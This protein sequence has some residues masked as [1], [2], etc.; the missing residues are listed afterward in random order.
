MKLLYF[1]KNKMSQAKQILKMYYLPT[2]TL[3]VSASI[4][5]TMHVSI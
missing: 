4:Y 1:F 5:L 2:Q 3:L